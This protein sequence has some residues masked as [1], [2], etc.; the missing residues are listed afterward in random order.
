MTEALR[1]AEP[2]ALRAPTLARTW[3]EALRA[4]RRLATRPEE[5]RARAGGVTWAQRA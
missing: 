3:P 1:D 4:P 2:E 5:T